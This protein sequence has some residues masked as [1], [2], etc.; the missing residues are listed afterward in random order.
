MDPNSKMGTPREIRKNKSLA[1]E[2]TQLRNAKK[3]VAKPWKQ[4]QEG[5]TPGRKT[6]NLAQ[7]VL[8]SRTTTIQSARPVLVC[9]V[10]C[11]APS[12]TQSPPLMKVLDSPLCCANISPKR[13]KG[14]HQPLERPGNGT[15]FG[16]TDID[17]HIARYNN[18]LLRTG[19]VVVMAVLYC[20]VILASMLSY[21]GVSACSCMLEHPQQYSCSADFGV[22]IVSPAPSLVT[23]VSHSAVRG[24]IP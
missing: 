7:K 9:A 10:R 12:P 16:A 6:L 11:P 4:P 13:L 3:E 8:G 14:K 15:L 5:A 22:T 21:T 1:K 23:S 2:G 19:S 17:P 20:V 24:A 18:D